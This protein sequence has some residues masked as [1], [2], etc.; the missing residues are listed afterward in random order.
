MGWLSW[1]KA[2]VFLSP[3]ANSWLTGKVPDAKKDWGQKEKRAS[4]DEMAGCHHQGHEFGQ[5]SGEGQGRLE[6]CS[7]WGCKE[8]E[9][10]G[11]WTTTLYYEGIKENTFLKNIISLTWSA[12]FKVIVVLKNLTAD[13]DKEWGLRFHKTKSHQFPR[14][15]PLNANMWWDLIKDHYQVVSISV[16]QYSTK[17]V[18]AI[19]RKRYTYLKAEFQRIEKG[20][21]KA[22]FNE[23]CREIVENNRK[24][25]RF[26]QE[27][28]RYKGNI[29]CKDGMINDINGKI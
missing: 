5:T 29:S 7:P 23:Q 21:E 18:V 8:S 12:F 24:N 27:I 26:L 9:C 6:C 25:Y 16:K 17:T 3:D 11:D 10:M 1:S 20:N 19:E 22:F 13:T 28:W 2:P 14:V 4:E 15:K